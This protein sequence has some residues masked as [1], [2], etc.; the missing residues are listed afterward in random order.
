MGFIPPAPSAAAGGGGRRRG[1][2]PVGTICAPGAHA[3]RLETRC[4]VAKRMPVHLTDS[5]A[6][7]ARA[8]GIFWRG[9]GAGISC[10][11]PWQKM[12]GYLFP[13]CK[14]I[15]CVGGKGRGMCQK[16]EGGAKD[17]GVSAVRPAAARAVDAGAPRSVRRRRGACQRKGWKGGGGLVVVSTNTGGANQAR[18]RQQ[19]AR[20]D[21]SWKAWV[22]PA[23]Q[24]H[25]RC[26]DRPRIS[27]ARSRCAPATSS[28]PTKGLGIHP[29]PS[30][31]PPPRRFAAR[32]EPLNGMLEPC[33][34]HLPCARCEAPATH[35]RH[36]AAE[37]P[38][39][40]QQQLRTRDPR[41]P[42]HM[43]KMHTT[44]EDNLE[45]T[46]VRRPRGLV[47]MGVHS[48]PGRPGSTPCRPGMMI[49]LLTPDRPRVDQVDSGSTP[50]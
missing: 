23:T 35:R 8:I 46:C 6:G 17:I 44:T 19:L 29:S 41:Q 2:A 4:D 20:Q 37:Q 26:T 50:G 16:W 47:S 10:P 27:P 13:G 28:T 34:R 3:H 15:P 36:P 14:K 32:I 18:C 25:H 22:V 21:N 45:E 40:L 7:V 30:L 39:Q 9:R 12:V 42:W 49:F 24:R 43:S 5:G 1:G 31:P 11:P 48:T 33:R 38:P